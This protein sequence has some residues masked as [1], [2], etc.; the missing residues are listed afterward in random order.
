MNKL[1]K[2]SCWYVSC[3][4]FRPKDLLKTDSASFG[5]FCVYVWW[6]EGGGCVCLFQYDECLKIL[7]TKVSEKMAYVKKV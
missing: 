7:Y 3:Q 5:L 1:I 6:V 2:N 4:L